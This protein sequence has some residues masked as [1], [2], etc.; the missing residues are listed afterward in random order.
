[1]K[2]NSFWTIPEAVYYTEIE[3]KKKKLGPEKRKIVALG[4][5]GATLGS[6]CR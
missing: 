5:Q 2:K 3:T 1:M 6:L 4:E